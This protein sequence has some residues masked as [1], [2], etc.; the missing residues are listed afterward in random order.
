M[1]ASGS[2][3]SAG[4]AVTS[5]AETVLSRPI[6]NVTV[7]GR[8]QVP[9]ARRCPGSCPASASGTRCCALVVDEGEELA[10][11][12]RA[13]PSRPDARIARCPHRDD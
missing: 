1:H 3:R 12:V 6:T 5:P 10:V 9:L 11:G 13:G 2:I 7:A 4:W 8:R